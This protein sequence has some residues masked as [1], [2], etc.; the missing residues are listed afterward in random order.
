METH[1]RAATAAASPRE[2]R[3][4]RASRSSRPRR[5]GRWTVA[6]GAALAIVVAGSFSTLAG[7]LVGPLHEEL[8]WSR[9]AI[10]LGS[11][12]NMVV[13]GATAPFAASL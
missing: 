7:L 4:S 2:S 5:D 3:A 13:Y 9:S 10:G 12:V 11:L 1:S 6:A 8:G